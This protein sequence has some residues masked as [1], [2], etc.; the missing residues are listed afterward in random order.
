MEIDPC[1]VRKLQQQA[2]VRLWM[3]TKSGG[4]MKE[5]MSRI[6]LKASSSTDAHSRGIDPRQSAQPPKAV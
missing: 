4:E 1:R 6:H 2:G 5:L 3:S